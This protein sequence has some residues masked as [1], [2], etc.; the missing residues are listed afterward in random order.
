M[1]SIEKKNS[2]TWKNPLKLAF[3]KVRKVMSVCFEYVNAQWPLYVL[4]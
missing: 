3:E 2:L 1:G 4:F